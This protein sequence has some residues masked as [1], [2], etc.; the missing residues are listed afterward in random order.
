MKLTDIIRQNREQILA[1]WQGM[2]F[3]TYS[4]KASSFM[5]SGKDKFSN[6]VGF[7]IKESTTLIFDQ[8]LDGVDLE[9]LK[10]A[11]DNIVRIRS[12]QEFSS[13]EATLFIFLLK[14][15][16]QKALETQDFSKDIYF[17]LNE[18]YST[19]DKISLMAFDI[20]VECREMIFEI[21]ANS[22]RMRSYK[23]LERAI[24]PA[25]QE[26]KGEERDD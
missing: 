5:A 10:P 22:V 12:V 18:I 23:L 26:P 16:I 13:S 3:E 17:E 9:K 19:I 8:L 4:D 24:S 20:Y 2:I 1:N 7:A 25:D 11:I 15:C 14:Q 21:K 6:P